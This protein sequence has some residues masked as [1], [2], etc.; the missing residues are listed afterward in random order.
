MDKKGNALGEI[1]LTYDADLKVMN[2]PQVTVPAPGGNFTFAPEVGGK[3]TDPN[4]R[5][6]FLLVGVFDGKKLTLAFAMPEDDRGSL[7]F[8]LRADPGV[9][10]GM[11]VGGAGVNV[12]GGGVGTLVYKIEMTPFSPFGPPVPVEK[13]ESGPFAARHE[14]SGENYAIHW[15][16][17][18]IGGEQRNVEITPELELALQQLRER[19][20]L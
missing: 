5:R 18:Q 14:D 4:P 6:R 9:S 19:L 12:P 7:E 1:E 13:R 3:L 8:T 16:A 10:V 20:G 15:S 17:R 2:L 11:G